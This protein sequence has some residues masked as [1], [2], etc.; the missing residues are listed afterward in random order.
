MPRIEICSRPIETDTALA[1]F[2]E[3]EEVGA[4]VTFSG[5]V[6]AQDEGKRID[7]LT[8]EHYPGMT[9]RRLQV[10]AEEA[11]RRWKLADCL[12]L[13]RV[14]RLSPGETIVL[15]A[16]AARHRRAAFDAAAY[17]MDWLKTDA[18]FWKRE[19]TPR[20]EQWVEARDSDDE[21]AARW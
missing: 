9:E 2:G 6:R 5:R 15:V 10:I 16:T 4:V 21:A 14:G 20:G 8:L 19:T 1:A 3:N 7:A 18:P 11:I 12:I 13:H 17:L